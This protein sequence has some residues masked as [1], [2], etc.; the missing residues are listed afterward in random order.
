MIIPINNY[1]LVE[2]IEKEK[3]QN[4]YLK[5]ESFYRVVK[6]DDE[7]FQKSDMLIVNGQTEMDS[8]PYENYFFIPVSDIIAIIRENKNGK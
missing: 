1:I 5:E 3:A 2:K 4:I 7:K 8:I 6:S